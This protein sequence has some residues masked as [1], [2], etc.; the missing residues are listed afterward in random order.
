MKEPR[1]ATPPSETPPWAAGA[2][3]RMHELDPVL[4]EE[5]MNVLRSYGEEKSFRAGALEGEGIFVESDVAPLYC[6]KNSGFIFLAPM[7]RTNV[8]QFKKHSLTNQN[9]LF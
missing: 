2:S 5:E 1:Q 4:N 7:K 3:E 6:V 9:G 8:G